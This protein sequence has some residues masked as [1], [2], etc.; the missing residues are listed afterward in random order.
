MPSILLTD[1]SQ[2]VW[3]ESLAIGPRDLGLPIG[4]DWSIVK[5]TRRGGRGHGVDLIEIRGGD[6]EFAVVPTRGMG[7]WRGSYRGDRLGWD[8]PVTDGPVHPMFVNSAKNGGL[9]WLD[10]FDELLARCGLESNGAPYVETSADGRQ[11]IVG[12]HGAIAGLPAHYV[13]IDIDEKPP[14][15]ITIE[16]RVDESRLF[17]PHIRMCSKIATVPGSNRLTVTDTFTN[18][19]DSACDLEALYHWN[20]GP[21]YLGAGSRFVAPIKTLVPRDTR[22]VEGLSSYDVYRGPEPGFAEMVYFMELFDRSGET[23]VLLQ[24]HAGEK[25][26][27]LRYQT[28]GT[29]AFTLWKCTRVER[30]GYVTGLEPGTNY[31]NPKPFEKSRGRVVSLDPGASHTAVISLEILA[32]SAEIQKIT[33]EIALIAKGR[34]ANVHPGPVEP[35]CKA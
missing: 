18:L 23:I 16:G 7:I 2:N 31:P 11:T 35:F 27:A 9:G 17:G 15:T 12:L 1:I 13:S 26:V 29:P 10:G 32:G 3:V 28:A 8:S 4:A 5:K 14:Y 30:E 33:S 34:P 19:G 25:G 20:F 24:N 22:A 6:L 21:P